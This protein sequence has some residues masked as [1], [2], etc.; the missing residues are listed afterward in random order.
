MNGIALLMIAATLGVEY[1]WRTTD[2]GQIEYVLIVEPDFITALA[3]GS[4]IRSSV[5]PELESVQRLCIRIAPPANAAAAPRPES[6]QRKLPAS[7]FLT[8][9]AGQR[10][11]E[12]MTI[13]WKANGQPEENISVRYGWQ[14]T[15]EG[16]LEYFVQVD[17]KLLRTLVPGDE[18]Y[19]LLS[20][21]A[22]RVDTFVV[23]SN[24]KPLPR[25]AGRP[26]AAPLGA[27][28]LANAPLGATPFAA[29]DTSKTRPA[30][31]TPPLGPGSTNLNGSSNPYSPYSST[32]TAP[33]P[34][35]PLGPAPGSTAPPSQFN[36]TTPPTT[37]GTAPAANDRFAS[38]TPRG[39][40]TTGD[41]TLE[42]SR[43]NPATGYEPVQ[44]GLNNGGYQNPNPRT[45]MTRPNL[46]APQLPSM[47]PPANGYANDFRNTGLNPGLRDNS[48]PNQQPAADPYAPRDPYRQDPPLPTAPRNDLFP[49]NNNNYANNPYPNNPQTPAYR[50][51][52]QLPPAGNV[53]YRPTV[54]S[55]QDNLAGRGFNDPNMPTGQSA[56]YGST[57]PDNRMASLSNAPLSLP[58][59]R[60]DSRGNPLAPG[61]EPEKPWWTLLF[62]VIILFFS[63][64]ANLYLGWTAAEFYSRYRLAVERLRSSGGRG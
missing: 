9:R 52:D 18:I 22:G 5:P 53:P 45:D 11:G 21:E 41:S 31:S 8:S 60:V 30:L 37:T 24:T 19:T 62:T 28:P 40:G 17:P 6:Q 57:S 56:N 36:W 44:P 51:N 35:A 49:S 54:G 1:D 64:G 63:I 50:P 7:A 29:N 3:E 61:V 34:L 27:A 58:P 55:P 13:L 43:V 42:N 4:E 33:A 10:P 48:L 46:G 25:V 32:G 12:P 16:L 2:D 38:N 15:K 47:Q 14:P 20:T 59:A 39:F 26:A 23:F